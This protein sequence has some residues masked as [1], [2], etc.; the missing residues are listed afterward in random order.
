M[1]KIFTFIFAAALAVSC[2]GTEIQIVSG[3]S[4]NNNVPLSNSGSY[5]VCQFIIPSSF[6]SAAPSTEHNISSIS[7]NYAVS[8][9]SSE[10]SIDVYMS[11]TTKENYGFQ[12][13]TV[14]V[15]SSDRVFSGV[16]TLPTS[17]N[18]FYAINFSNRFAWDGSSNIL[19]TVV[20]KTGEINTGISHYAKNYS[21]S[22][23]CVYTT[24][25]SVK[26]PT[27]QISSTL[28]T[29]LPELK[30][31]FCAAGPDAPTNV[32]VA[33]TTS[34]SATI[35]WTKKSEATIK[36]QYKL[37]TDVSWTTVVED[38]NAS[39]YT[40]TGLT[41]G[42]Q[43]DYKVMAKEGGQESSPVEGSFT[44]AIAGHEHN[45]ITFNPWNETTSMPNEAGS[46]YLTQ[47]VSLNKWVLPAGNTNICLNGH[48]ITITNTS[49]VDYVNIG[50]GK[51]LSI[52][53][54]EGNGVITA[55]LSSC[56]TIKVNGGSLSLYGGSVNN[57]ASGTDAFAVNVASGTFN[58]KGN[59][60]MSTLGSAANIYLQN[61][62][63]I[64]LTGVITNSD[65]L[66]VKKNAN[67]NITSGWSTQMGSA[68]P[69][70]YFL[71]KNSDAP[72]VV[73]V[74]GEAQLSVPEVT[75]SETGTNIF[76][77][78]LKNVNLVRTFQ[79]G[80]LN[81]ISLP[82]ALTNAQLEAKFGD[83]Y[84]LYEL[85]SS[86]LSNGVLSLMFN[87]VTALD[88]GYPYLLRI[89]SAV[90]NPSFSSVNLTTENHTKQTT[91][92]NMVAVISEKNVANYENVLFLNAA[93]ELNWSTAAGNFRGMRAYFQLNNGSPSNISARRIVL[94]TDATTGL[95]QNVECTMQ[96]DK[97]M[98]NGQLFIIKN[99]VTYNA[100]GQIVK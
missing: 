25:T 38:L 57:T 28:S 65:K 18:N 2:W 81:T 82:F 92:V 53:D 5:S 8:K 99:G 83:D 63:V 86:S 80:I 91:A 98:I 1:K 72:A 19:V 73:L 62:C 54:N 69:A 64:T 78:G 31:N 89:S 51:N 30:F 87:K 49:G 42:T 93:G 39:S 50:E 4:S 13:K 46:Y 75:I 27:S 37:H 52:Y 21:S 79:A 88:D 9:K 94:G 7:F 95:M 34:T 45:D 29:C 15:S 24:S 61:S 12:G 47:N 48:T 56:A 20:D 10:R 17:M 26:D 77:A 43:Y 71:S 36:L 74:S 35:G 84:E 59:V 67:S 3:G 76:T 22:N 70:N 33:A 6:L 32:S 96:N 11:N 14:P 58:I 68:D 40:I 90:V 100:Q 55:A 16:V 85:G 44:T 60:K 23:Y 41:S 97:V 66:S